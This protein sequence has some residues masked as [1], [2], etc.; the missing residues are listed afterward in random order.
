MRGTTLRYRTEQ[1]S[2]T[3]LKPM[4]KNQFSL[5]GPQSITD[6]PLRNQTILAFAGLALLLLARA[7]ANRRGEGQ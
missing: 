1:P 6:Y 3:A 2:T 7:G 4:S 5:S